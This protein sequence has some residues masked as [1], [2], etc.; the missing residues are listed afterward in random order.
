MLMMIALLLAVVIYWASCGRSCLAS[1]RG[2]PPQLP[3]P[4]FKVR[5]SRLRTRPTGRER[6]AWSL[7]R[8]TAAAAGVDVVIAM[9]QVSSVSSFPGQLSA[10]LRLAVSTGNDQRLTI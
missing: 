9:R 6:R 7:L 1:G 8:R 3:R 5:V 10:A 2:D 4:I